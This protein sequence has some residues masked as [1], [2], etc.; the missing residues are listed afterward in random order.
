MRIVAA[1]RFENYFRE[2][3]ELLVEHANDPVAKAY[4]SCQSSASWPT[5]TG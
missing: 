4:T 3:G 2:R 5:N 1:R